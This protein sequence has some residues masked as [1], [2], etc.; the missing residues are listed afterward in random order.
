MDNSHKNT[1]DFSPF[2]EKVLQAVKEYNM[3][4]PKDKVIVGL[5]GGA[6]SVTLL[7]SLFSLKEALDIELYA[8]HINHNL[9]GED[10]DSDQRFAESFCKSLD[11]PLRVFSVDVKGALQ[12]HQST[13]E[14][15]RKLRYEKFS[16]YAKEIGMIGKGGAKVATAHN[17]CDNSETVL[18]NLI[19]GT[20]LKGL[21]GIPPVRDCFIRPLIYCTREEIEEYIG[22]NSLKY[23]TD[24]T[25]FSTDYTRN[26]VRLQLMPLLLE[27]NPSFHRGVSRMVSALRKDSDYLEEMA[28]SALDNARLEEG[29]YSSEKLAALDPPILSRSVSLMLWEKQVEPS[30]LRINGFTEIIKDGRGKINLEKNKFAVVRKGRAEV[31]IIEQ[32]YR[33]RKIKKG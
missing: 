27:M 32:K 18:L 8:C 20:G 2:L 29:V 31:Q 17:A 3:L 12:K 15:A 19:R 21:C 1:S 6:D 30:A 9:R 24:K 22:A 13:E 23:V 4:K 26:K 33:E 14:I 10:S 11:I 5:S 7:H 16:E 25:N 28:V